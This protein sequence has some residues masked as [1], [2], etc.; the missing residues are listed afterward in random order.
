MRKSLSIL[1]FKGG[2][3]TAPL[4]RSPLFRTADFNCRVNGTI[5]GLLRSLIN[6]AGKT[7]SRFIA[8]GAII[9]LRL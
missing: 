5:R 4:A 6:Y 7:N 8:Q 9:D 3:I 1:S 2:M